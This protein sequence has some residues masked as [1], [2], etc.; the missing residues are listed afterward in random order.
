MHT[1][2]VALG[3]RANYGFLVRKAWVASLGDPSKA[4]KLERE[5]TALDPSNYDARLIQGVYDYIVGSLPWHM[6]VLS[7]L[8]GYRGD[9]QRGIATL[10]E[11]AD[12]GK[13]N[14]DDA[15][16]LLCALYRRARQPNAAI[17]QG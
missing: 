10:E 15:E 9:K 11:V 13:E 14:H 16:I 3:L 4:Q 12:K 7:R 17:P 8:A 1:M 2:A 6:K 5:V